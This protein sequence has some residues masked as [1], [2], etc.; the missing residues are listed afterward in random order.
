MVGHKFWLKYNGT[1]FRQ[2][3]PFIIFHKTIRWAVF[4][5]VWEEKC[6]F[7]HLQNIFFLQSFLV[8]KSRIQIWTS[9]PK[10]PF[11]I[12]FV[13][14]TKSRNQI[15]TSSHNTS[16]CYNLS[17][18]RNPEFKSE[19]RYKK[20]LSPLCLSPSR[21]PEIKSELW[22]SKIFPICEHFFEKIP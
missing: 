13:S 1:S 4:K 21:N 15:W 9:V 2:T 19:L 17:L 8:P 10:R 12:M 11:P 18:W 14:L 20:D 6:D 22:H 7:S 5:K 3:N 16:F